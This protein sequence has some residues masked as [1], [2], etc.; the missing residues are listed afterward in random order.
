MQIT[1]FISREES[2]LIFVIVNTVG[3][4]VVLCIENL[5]IPR[6]FEFSELSLIKI[7]RERS[8]PY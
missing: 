7:Q 1:S 4:R 2:I 3:K 6:C 5:S 8:S